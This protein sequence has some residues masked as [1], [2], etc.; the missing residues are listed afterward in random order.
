MGDGEAVVIRGDARHLPL[1]D[2]SVDLIV[3][4]PPYWGLRSYTDGGQHYDGQIGS[5]V[6]PQEFLQALWECTAEWAR[7]LKPTGS[8]FVN[9]G[10]KYSDR[11]DGGPTSARSRRADA[12][13]VM[14]PGRSST[15]MAPRKSLLGLPALYAAGCTGAL[16]ALGGPNPGLNL[17]YRRDL[18]WHKTN[19]LPESVTDRCPTTH[20]Y[21]FHLTK[22]GRYYAAMDEIREPHTGTSHTQKR[23]PTGGHSGNGVRHRAF[24]GN[25]EAYNPLGKLPGSVWAIPSQQLHVPA[26]LAVDHFAAFPMEWPRRLI[27][28]WSPPGICLDCGEGRRPV[29]DASY[30]QQGRSTNG[31][32]S[33]ARHH[34]SPG[35]DVR[36]VR[37]TRITGYACACS[38][39]TAPTRPAVVLDPFGGTGTT[40]L[41]ASVL[42]RR[43]VSVDRSADYCRIAQW[44]TTDRNEIARAMQVSKPPVEVVGQSSLFD[45]EVPDAS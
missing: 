44:R 5:E 4:S 36:A 29:S 17:I 30:D 40:A 13:E 26:E 27:R 14:Q 18:I 3:T 10:D 45:E 43:G 35:R 33:V 8:M 25:V 1:A 31:P 15:S 20:E 39:P 2:A 32:Q 23:P 22:Q 34:E 9:L 41:V 11:A 16:A 21:W 28:G 37:L 19:P 12:A 42:G 24:A 7:V 6:A 38:E